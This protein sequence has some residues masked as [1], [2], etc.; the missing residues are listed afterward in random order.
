MKVE[1][2]F[3]ESQF[4]EV[5][6]VSFGQFFSNFE[7]GR[8]LNLPPHQLLIINDVISFCPMRNEVVRRQ[9]ISFCSLEAALRAFYCE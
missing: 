5:C 1:L 7:R 4:Y 9:M 6:L 2:F 3:S 8:P